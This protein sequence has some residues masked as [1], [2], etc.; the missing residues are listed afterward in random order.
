MYIREIADNSASVL[1][2]KL[3]LNNNNNNKNYYGR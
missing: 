2:T 3:T 1:T